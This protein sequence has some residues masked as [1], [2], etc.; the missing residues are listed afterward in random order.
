MISDCPSLYLPLLFAHGSFRVN[1]SDFRIIKS[2]AF[3]LLLE[4]E[5]VGLKK[6]K[7]RCQQQKPCKPPRSQLDSVALVSQ[8]PADGLDVTADREQP[9][10]NK[11][12]TSHRK[13]HC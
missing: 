11:I 8:H 6:T 12:E 5:H 13:Y 1:F 4:V 10:N 7:K 2:I 3:V 9:T